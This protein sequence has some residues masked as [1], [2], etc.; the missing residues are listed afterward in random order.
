MFRGIKH[1]AG[2]SKSCCWRVPVFR[3]SRT[4]MEHSQGI[5]PNLQ[6]VLRYP[7]LHGLS[8]ALPAVDLKHIPQ[9][10]SQSIQLHHRCKTYLTYTLFYAHKNCLYVSGKASQSGCDSFTTHFTLSVRCP[11][12]LLCCLVRYWSYSWAR[13]A[14]STCSRLNSGWWEKI[15]P[16]ISTSS[17]KSPSGS[18]APAI[19]RF[20]YLDLSAWGTGEHNPSRNVLEN[21]NHNVIH[22]VHAI[23]FPLS[24]KE[25]VGKIDSTNR[26]CCNEKSCVTTMYHKH[27]TEPQ[28]MLSF[29]DDHIWQLCLQNT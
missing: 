9:C 20:A 18:V 27:T 14:P 4:W 12:R 16:E 5:S 17:W 13:R 23:R 10:A 28:W 15:S 25:V 7:L 21:A 1:A 11:V 24:L 19:Y 8:E 6:A 26:E 29:L 2:I 3:L 22:S